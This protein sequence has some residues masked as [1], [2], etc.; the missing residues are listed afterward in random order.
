MPITKTNVAARKKRYSHSFE[1]GGGRAEE[2][3]SLTPIPSSP[4]DGLRAGEEE[5]EDKGV[6]RR[7][8]PHSCRAVMRQK[9][10]ELT[11]FQNSAMYDDT[12]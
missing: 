6:Y 9:A 10:R 7:S 5:R 3:R 8:I 11:L 1:S 4:S 2:E 12:A